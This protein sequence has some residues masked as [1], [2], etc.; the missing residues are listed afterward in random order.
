MNMCS[1]MQNAR[2]SLFSCYCFLPDVLQLILGL[3]LIILLEKKIEIVKDP[4]QQFSKM[5]CLPQLSQ[6][7]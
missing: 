4:G 1:G 5:F 6:H 3:D 2:L 7:I